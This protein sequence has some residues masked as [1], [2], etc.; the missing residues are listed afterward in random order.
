M[1]LLRLCAVGV[2]LAALPAG[3]CGGGD[4]SR[5]IRVAPNSIP[6]GPYPVD[7]LGHDPSKFTW[8]WSAGRPIADVLVDPPTALEG[9]HQLG[10][11]FDGCFTGDTV[12]INFRGPGAYGVRVVYQD[13]S[14]PPDVR[15]VL[16]SATMGRAK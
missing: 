4:G 9:P 10:K 1:R 13:P 15:I 11:D 14:A 12:R 6:A 5:P 2:I 7:N 16:V 8:V 3:G